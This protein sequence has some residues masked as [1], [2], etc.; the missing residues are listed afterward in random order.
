MTVARRHRRAASGRL[1]RSL[2]L[3]NLGVGQLAPAYRPSGAKSCR[4]TRASVSAPAVAQIRR[5]NQRQNRVRRQAG[6]ESGTPPVQAPVLALPLFLSSPRS[7]CRRHYAAAGAFIHFSLAP[8][9][10]SI[11]ITTDNINNKPA[12]WAPLETRLL[13]LNG[14][15]LRRAEPLAGSLARPLDGTGASKRG[16]QLPNN[17]E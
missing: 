3:I 7:R 1:G 15:C 4:D 2:A 6:A 5:P 17:T 13:C 11:M 12:I 16:G 8:P 14:A 10:Q 9:R